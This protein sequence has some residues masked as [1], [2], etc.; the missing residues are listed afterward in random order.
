MGKRRILS[1]EGALAGRIMREDDTPLEVAADIA[2]GINPEI[3]GRS[4]S[5]SCPL[6]GTKQQSKDP[7]DQINCAGCGNMYTP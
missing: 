1:S 2:A 4:Y 7:L 3:A 6:C 5:Y